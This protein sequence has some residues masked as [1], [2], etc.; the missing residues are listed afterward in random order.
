[1]L[2][3]RKRRGGTDRRNS[4]LRGGYGYKTAGRRL[5]SK[6]ARRRFFLLNL[7]I[8]IWPKPALNAADGFCRKVYLRAIV[9]LIFENEPS[10]LAML[11]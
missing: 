1:M 8:Q 4:W 10:G 6:R 3:K 2:R 11:V 7:V 5:M 9:P